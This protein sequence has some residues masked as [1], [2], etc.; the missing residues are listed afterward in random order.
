M[1]FREVSDEFLKLDE[2]DDDVYLATYESDEEITQKAARDFVRANYRDFYFTDI[3]WEIDGKRLLIT[4]SV[5][6]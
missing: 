2:Y 5:V 4:Y 3:D 1:M 6:E